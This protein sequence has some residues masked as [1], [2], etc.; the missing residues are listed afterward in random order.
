MSTDCFPDATKEWPKSPIG[1]LADVNPRYSVKKGIDYPFIEMAS[2]GENFGGILKIETRKLESSGM[3]RFKMGDTLFAKITP[4]PENGKVAFV[5]NIPSEIGIGS[6]EFIVLSP[7]PTCSGRFLFHLVCSHN[8]RARAVSRMEGSTGRQRV[9]DE[10]FTKR[11]LIPVPSPEEQSAIASILDAVE[12][13]IERTQEAVERAREV[14]RALV[15][16]LFS[17]GTRK[18]PQKKSPIGF[19]PRS[20]DALSANAVVREFQYGLSKPMDLKG[21]IPILR[22]GNIQSGDVVFNELKY[23]SLPERFI[24]PYVVR[25]GDVLFN[26]TNSQEWVGKIGVYRSDRPTVFA[27]YLI[28]LHPDPEK[29]DNYFLGQVL[30]SYPAQCRIKRYATPGV[31]Q[32]NINATNLGKVLIP[33]PVGKAALDE[34]REIAKILEQADQRVRNYGPVIDGLLQLKKSL[35][36]DLLNGKVR[37]GQ[38]HHEPSLQA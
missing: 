25:R 29:I 16:D 13:A 9:P 30:N 22:M 5:E 2:V 4:C 7:K 20:W 15:Q 3:S 26:R 35:M 21:D 27:S 31:Q 34:Q 23:L 18:E 14:K 33:V 32:V 24:T 11:F 12:A 10:V 17:K 36:Y 37:V 38:R 1:L 19:I 28:R 6:T 8:I